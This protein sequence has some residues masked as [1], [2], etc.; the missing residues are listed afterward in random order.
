L[1]YQTRFKRKVS[2]NCFLRVLVMQSR[3]CY[4]QRNS[5]NCLLCCVLV[6]LCHH[7]DCCV[8]NIH[9]TVE[10]AIA[11]PADFTVA[12]NFSDSAATA[13]CPYEHLQE[14][15]LIPSPLEK[16]CYYFAEHG[17]SEH[18]V[19][20]LASQDETSHEITRHLPQDC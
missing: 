16:S 14:E 18:A 5:N 9:L 10:V 2:L 1:Q 7:E 15:Y 17:C 11:D 4:P 20:Y 8:F 6:G 13:S 3:H 12:K 19:S